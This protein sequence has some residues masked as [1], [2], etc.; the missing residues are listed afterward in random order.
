MEIISSLDNY[1]P[2]WEGC[3]LTMGDFDGMHTGHR[4]LIKTTIQQAEKLTL[5]SVLLTYDPSPK[6]TLQKLKHDESIYTR[7]EKI[8]LLQN[9]SLHAVIFLPFNKDILH[10][11]AK[12]FLKNI[13]LKQLKVKK[14]IFGYD[15]K[16]G[17]N[18]HGNYKYL[19]LAQRKYDF[20]VKSIKEVKMFKRTVSSSRIRKLLKEGQI[21]SINR[22]FFVPYFI[23]GTVILGKQR[24]KT[25][26]IPTANLK[27]SPDKLLPKAGVYFCITRRD[28]CSFITVVNIGKNPTFEHDKIDLSIEAHLLDFDENIYNE[29]LTLFFIHRI[30]DEKKF[31]NVEQLKEQIAIDIK[32]AKKMA[33]SFFKNKEIKYLLENL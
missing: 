27:V 33:I 8:M 7:V 11:T 6:K 26:G 16:F 1:T 29:L 3:V 23:Q 19:N 17:R 13:L 30:R 9:F 14:L 4:K 22:F 25:M 24:G 21:A 2:N 18:R 12:S 32:Q 10:M 15:H 20:K 31:L 5:A 28:K